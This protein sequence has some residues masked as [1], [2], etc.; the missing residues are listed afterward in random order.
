MHG[1]QPFRSAKAKHVSR[2]GFVEV[3]TM[4]LYEKPVAKHCLIRRFFWGLNSALQ[5]GVD[6][7][8]RGN[9][10]SDG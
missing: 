10:A 5:Q 6:A 2:L 4:I 3:K 9:T 8:P 1:G 7:I